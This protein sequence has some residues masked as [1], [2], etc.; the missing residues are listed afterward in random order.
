[1]GVDR[2]PIPWSEIPNAD[3]LLVVGANVGEC[4]PITTSYIWRCRDRGGRL[5]VVDPR[6]TPIARNADLYLPVRP[7]TD[8]QLLMG[9]LHVIVRDGLVDR[10]F[11][12]AHTTGFDEVAADA[13]TYDLEH[14]AD[15]TGVPPQAIE[16][17]ARMFATA[18]RAI[19]LHARGLEHHS[20]GV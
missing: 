15:R 19:A 11:I 18:D 10:A 20:K 8:L 6:M 12:D 5:I 3:V 16:Q 17:A 2:S 7:G 1:F 9:M 14:V 4:A 13:A